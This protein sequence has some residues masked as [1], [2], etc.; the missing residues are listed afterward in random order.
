MLAKNSGTDYDLKWVT[1]SGGG[2]VD[3]ELSTTSTN[4]VQNKIITRAINFT[5]DM[6]G[7]E[8]IVFTSGGYIFTAYSAGTTVSLTPTS[9]AN[10][11]YAII[12]CTAGDKIHING[13]GAGNAYLW[14]FIDSSDKMIEKSTEGLT[15][16]DLVVI[17]PENSAKVILNSKLSS[18]GQCLKGSI[19]KND[20][21]ELQT[22]VEGIKSQ[23]LLQQSDLVIANS[24]FVVKDGLAYAVSV[25]SPYNCMAVNTKKINFKYRR[26]SSTNSFY[27]GVC[28][29][30]KF[31][32]NRTNAVV[33]EIK[34]LYST[35]NAVYANAV[36]NQSVADDTYSTD[37]NNYTA[38][39]TGQVFELKKGQTTI[40]KFTVADGIAI[41]GIAF[42]NYY[43]QYYGTTD[44]TDFKDGIVVVDE[45]EEKVALAEQK[46]SDIDIIGNNA[47]HRMVAGV[48]RN[49]GSGWEFIVNDRHQGDM[50]CVDVGIDENDGR[51]YV[52][53]SGINVKKVISYICAPDEAFANDGYI[54][55]ASVGLDA[56]YIQIYQY[57]MSS[58]SARIT[59][60][61][62]DGTISPTISESDGVS[63]AVWDDTNK[64][65]SIT[66]TNIVTKTASTAPIISFI[67]A[68][69]GKYLMRLYSYSGTT[70]KVEFFDLVTGNKVTAPDTSMSLIFSRIGSALEKIEVDPSTLVSASGNIWF[71]GIF[72]V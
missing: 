70:A 10:Y 62:S 22:T 27:V 53:Y 31:V 20:V 5:D 36:V 40:L 55:G 71:M 29:D 25:T 28:I 39:L 19:I 47:K 54:M 64:A 34:T 13:E 65:L 60:Q 69:Y 45:I 44:N 68:V 50:N 30:G 41:Q 17:A 1:L 49:T 26:R 23:H 7:A 37:Y 14:S 57:R 52:D 24:N 67:P 2:T 9:N 32:G 4:P 58:V 48:I 12:D 63:S 38:T 3:D 8:E 66:H 46:F 35:T 15:G 16:T 59:F 6:I 61:N 33:T 56:A 18:L 42:L 51:L 43:F 72:E 21:A 11:A